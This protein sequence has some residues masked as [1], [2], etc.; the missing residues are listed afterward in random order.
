MQPLSTNRIYTPFVL[1]ITILIGI[2]V[3]KPLYEA[4]QGREIQRAT[5][6]TQKSEKT[7]IYN[8]LLEM[9]STFVLTNT[10]SKINSGT[11]NNTGA[12]KFIDQ[13]NRLSKKWD[14]SEIMAVVMLNNFTLSNSTLT[15][16]RISIGDLSVNHGAKLPSWLSLGGISFSVT[17]GTLTD[18][19]DYIAYLTQSSPYVFTIDAISL[20]IDTA[21]PGF[22]TDKSISL[23]LSLGIYY[24]E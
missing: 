4:Y 17:A 22:M 9:Q 3:T 21:E 14:T 16:A 7:K 20:P 1:G 12:T 18:L 2:F 8:D 24:Y 10:G 5:L 6:V 15:P 13:V 23:S 19:I 11:L